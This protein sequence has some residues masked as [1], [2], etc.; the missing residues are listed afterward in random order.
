VAR[1]TPL[2]RETVADSHGEAPVSNPRVRYSVKATTEVNVGSAVKTFQLVNVG[3]QLCAKHPTCSPDGKWKAAEGSL[4]LDAGEGNEF[5]NA[6]VSCIAGPCPFTQVEQEKFSDDR[7]RLTVTVRDWS[8]TTTFLVEAEVVHPMT[9]DM[10]RH[11]YPVIF[12]RAL[13]FSLPPGAEGPSIEAEVNGESIVFPLGPDLFLR[14]A[15][16]QIVAEK[17]E[18]QNYRC[19]LKRGYQFR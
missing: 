6:R 7:R 14:W 3:N 15:D 1:M 17:D 12:G 8:D 10:V 18:S 19:E 9:S 2:H 13:N 11:T 4:S 16:C 5:R